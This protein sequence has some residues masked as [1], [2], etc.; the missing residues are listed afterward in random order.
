MAEPLTPEQAREQFRKVSAGR[1]VR[2]SL[3]IDEAKARLREVDAEL[4]IS[5]AIDYLN[6]REWRNAL[7][8]LIYWTSTP[9][10]RAALAP[11]LL[12]LIPIVSLVLG[13]LH[14]LF[15]HKSDQKPEAAPPDNDP[16]AGSG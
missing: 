8:Y 1:R 2:Q 5:P 13:L 7:F 10:G 12:R 6:R 4:E 15:V 9:N 14:R 16:A 3:S 11:V